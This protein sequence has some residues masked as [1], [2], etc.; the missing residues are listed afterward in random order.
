MRRLAR[1]L[2]VAALLFG[3]FTLASSEWASIAIAAPTGAQILAALDDPAG[4]TEVGVSKGVSVYKKTIA[5]VS[6]P[7]LKGVRVATVN[8]DAVWARIANIAGQKTVN[9]LLA[10]S[11]VIKKEGSSL[12]FYQ[13]LKGPLPGVS[14]RYWINAAK[15][16]R[17]VNGEAGHHK[18]T[19]ELLPETSYPEVHAQIKATYGDDAVWTP[20]NYGSWE[21]ID[22]G[23]GQ[24]EIT[25][26]VV[27]H[28]GGNVPDGAFSWGSEKSLPDNINGFIKA[29]GGT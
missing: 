6:V 5:G 7:A 23:A 15:N 28:P 16:M 2:S 3:G 20:L 24:T 12:D 18:Q 14:V 1:F 11:V 19:W 10:E 8:A 22:K 9:P 13:V 27:S 4:W 17:S 26:R 25:Y 21:V 29:A